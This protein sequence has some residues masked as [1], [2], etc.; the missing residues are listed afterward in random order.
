MVTWKVTVADAEAASVPM[1]TVT[2]L[3]VV[4]PK[5]ASSPSLASVFA[6][7]FKV[8]LAATYVVLVGTVSV[9]MTLLAV[10]PPPFETSTVYVNTV[11]GG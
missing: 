5:S 4:T 1:F 10:L 3:A 2:A 11:P 6:T 9:K 7:A 8:M